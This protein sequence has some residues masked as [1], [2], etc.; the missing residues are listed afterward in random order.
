MA[1]ASPLKASCE[2]IGKAVADLYMSNGQ[3]HYTRICKGDAVLKAWRGE[4]THQAVLSQFVWVQIGK[5]RVPF[6]E[7][8][9]KTTPQI[10]PEIGDGGWGE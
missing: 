4:N 1:P 3:A 6:G 9:P 10:S 8:P 5:A 2:R 7:Y